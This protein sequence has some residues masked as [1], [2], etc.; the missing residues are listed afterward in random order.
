[1][2]F[3]KA[4]IAKITSKRQVTFP[5][6]VMEELN[7]KTGDT[8]SLQATSEGIL[9]RPHRLDVSKLAPLRD[10]VDM[11]LPA[12]DM[13]EIRRVSIHQNLRD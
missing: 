10:Q 11:N 9:I 7:L 3:S 1:M 8:L 2:T 12:P 5:K 6:K 13:E 4:M